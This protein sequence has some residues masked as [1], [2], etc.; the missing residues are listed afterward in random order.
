MRRAYLATLL[1]WLSLS[2]LGA[3]ANSIPRAE[4]LGA[5]DGRFGAVEAFWAPNEAAALGIGWERILFYWNQLQPFGPDDWNS[6]HVRDE[7][8][9]EARSQGRTVVG[10]L[11]NTPEWATDGVFAS[12]VPRGLFLPIDDPGNL[13]A[14]FTRRTASYY[15]DRGV[16]HWIIW[17]EPIAP[18][19][20]GHEFSGSLEEY[21]QLLKVAYLSI[22][23]VNPA[24]TIHLGGRQQLLF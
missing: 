21:F 14:A 10:L 24:A 20:Y 15:G 17:N 22:K 1:L 7:W 16:H 19:T 9:A 18:G 23:G 3:P 11:K 8:L 13:W 6:L 5:I 2:L 12:G 4:A